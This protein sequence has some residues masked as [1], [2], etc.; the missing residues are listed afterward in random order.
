M[1]SNIFE[2]GQGLDVFQTVL[3]SD[4]LRESGADNGVTDGSICRE[5]AH[6]LVL[7]AHILCHEGAG[8]ICIETNVRVRIVLGKWSILPYTCGVLDIDSQSVGIRVRCHNNV[9]IHLLC[10]LYTHCKCGRLLRIWI[11]NCREISIRCS[12]LFNYIYLCEAQTIKNLPNRHIS[13]TMKRCV[14]NCYIVS[15]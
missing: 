14:N 2:T 9:S 11:L 1:L 6:E 5:G 13:G 15:N 8:H 4:N 3:G 10:K 12:L 7:P